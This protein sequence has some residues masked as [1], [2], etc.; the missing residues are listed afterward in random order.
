[1]THA[2][3]EIAE[4]TYEIHSGAVG[5][6]DPSVY[7]ARLILEARRERDAALAEGV[8]LKRQVAM[9]KTEGKR[10][11]VKL[12]LHNMATMP[13]A[14]IEQVRQGAKDAVE[15]IEGMTLTKAKLTMTDGST[16]Y[17]WF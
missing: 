7:A 10:E 3:K 6:I 17:W 11:G 2:D 1:M 13:D 16:T 5:Y 8:E 4:V 15:K 14:T 9:A 12:A